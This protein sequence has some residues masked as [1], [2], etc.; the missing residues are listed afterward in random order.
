MLYEKCE[1]SKFSI[2]MTISSETRNK[3]NTSLTC[4]NRPTA[5]PTIRN[6]SWN[7]SKLTHTYPHKP[8]RKIKSHHTQSPGWQSTLCVAWCLIWWF[9]ILEKSGHTWHRMSSLASLNNK[10]KLKI[11]AKVGATT[12][13]HVPWEIQLNTILFINAWNKI[14]QSTNYTGRGCQFSKW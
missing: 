3:T 2:L 6:K 14:S 7:L 11:Y 10:H 9:A 5:C 4:T 8:L 12:R 1:G 13:H